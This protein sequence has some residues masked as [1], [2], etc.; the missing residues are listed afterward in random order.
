MLD[1]EVEK[2]VTKVEALVG[3]KDASLTVKDLV[4]TIV[5]LSDDVS[6]ANISHWKKDE[7]RNTLK[8]LKKKVDDVER[9][10]KAAVVHDVAEE[11]KKL[12]AQQLNQPFIVHEF[13]AFSNTK[14][15]CMR[16]SVLG[17]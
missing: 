1:K 11:A 7:L 16:L 3:K 14:V 10:V 2:I 8:A 17:A 15:H 5:D 12:I 13:F 6:Q 4:R 9:A